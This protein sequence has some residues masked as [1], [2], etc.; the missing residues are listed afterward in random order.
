M[1]LNVIAWQPEGSDG[2]VEWQIWAYSVAG[3]TFIG[4][5]ATILGG[6]GSV[7][8]EGSS[9][10]TCTATKP[11]PEDGF[12][13]PHNAFTMCPDDQVFKGAAAYIGGN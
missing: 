7:I 8:R 13:A 12:K 3:A 10:W 4:D 1:S 11:M 5:F 2:S 6:D 9:G